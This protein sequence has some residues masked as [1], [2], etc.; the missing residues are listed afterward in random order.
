MRKR[1][2]VSPTV[3]KTLETGVVAEP[4]SHP[5]TMRL[6]AA[7]LTIQSTLTFN[8][9]ATYNFWLN[10]SDVTAD[11]V[12]ALGVTINSG[13]QFSFADFGGAVLTRGIRLL[14]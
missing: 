13:A 9:D 14:L 1:T 2:D 11:E 7:L 10:T 8:P 3:P 12:V 4:L 5:G 6:P